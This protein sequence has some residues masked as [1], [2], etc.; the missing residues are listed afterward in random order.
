MTYAASPVFSSELSKLKNNG[1]NHAFFTREGGVSTGIYASLNVGQGSDD[2]T[3]N[4]LQNRTI[5][6]DYMGVALPNL[7]TVYQVHSS[8]AIVANE[9]FSGEKPK[10][11]ALVTN[12]PNLALGILT[13]DCGP[14]LFA[15]HNAGVIGAAHAG[16]R[17]ALGGIIENTIATME[18]LGAERRNIIAALGPCIGPKNYEVSEEFRQTFLNEDSTF[19]HFF[20]QTNKTDHYLFNL[21]AF[22]HHRL[23]QA[24]VKADG[25][26]LCTY[27]DEKRF[28]SYRR[29]TH[30]N[31]ADYGR[32]I[33]VI[34]LDNK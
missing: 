15:D 21:W 9:P 10:A 6:A 17:G 30:R 18:T 34:M 13:A 31:E 1:I 32:Q 20:H 29:K 5:V 26:D 28:F 8:L 12:K 25:L 33:S 19:D 14:V 4:V 2:I 23:Q 24:G 16:W 27:E 7:L 11:D 3:E 22:I